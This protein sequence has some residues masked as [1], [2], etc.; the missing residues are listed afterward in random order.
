AL[1]AV[2]VIASALSLHALPPDAE[3][4]WYATWLQ[5]IAAF[6]LAFALNRRNRQLTARARELCGDALEAG[7]LAPREVA[8]LALRAARGGA[9]RGAAGRGAVVG[10]GV[11]ATGQPQRPRMECRREGGPGSSRR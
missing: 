8:V 6:A 4:A 7:A 9:R 11:R 1:L 5:I 2:L 3:A 10:P